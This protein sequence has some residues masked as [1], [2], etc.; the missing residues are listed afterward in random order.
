[1]VQEMLTLLIPYPDAQVTF[2]IR[3]TSFQSSWEALQLLYAR[4][5]TT[6]TLWWSKSPMSIVS[7]RWIYTTLESDATSTTQ[8]R[9]KT[10]YDINGMAAFLKQ[11]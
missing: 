6:I 7:L 9:N 5:N 10:F 8:Y 4:P 2:P 11:L 3:A 1:M